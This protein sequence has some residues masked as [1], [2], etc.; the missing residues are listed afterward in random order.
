MKPQ[1]TPGSDS[2][3]TSRDKALVDIQKLKGKAKA[4]QDVL[5]GMVNLEQVISKPEVSIAFGGHC[6]A[7]KSSTL[8]ALLGQLILPVGNKPL[9]GV[10]IEIRSGSRD[11][12]ALINKDGSIR[13]IPCTQEGIAQACQL[14][15]MG[16]RRADISQIKNLQIQLRNSSIPT[17][18]V[19][20]D[21]PGIDDAAEMTD[22]AWNAAIDADL[23]VW[24]LTSR[25]PLSERETD[26]LTRYVLLRGTDSLLLVLNCFLDD[27]TDSAWEE[28]DQEVIPHAQYK[29]NEWLKKIGAKPIQIIPISAVGSDASIGHNRIEAARES[30]RKLENASN[31][32]VIQSRLRRSKQTATI[33]STSLTDQINTLQHDFDQKQ[34]FYDN[35]LQKYK[36][37]KK[38]A[39]RLKNDYEE[40][41]R[42]RLTEAASAIMAYANQ[43]AAQITNDNLKRDQTYSAGLQAGMAQIGANSK[44]NLLNDLRALGARHGITT[45]APTIQQV[46]NKLT[47]T[48]SASITVPKTESSAKWIGMFIGFLVGMFGSFGVAAIPGAILGFVV[49]YFIGNGT[50]SD[51]QA[52]QQLIQQWGRESSSGFIASQDYIN[53]LFVPP[54]VGQNTQYPPNDHVLKQTIGL[55]ADLNAFAQSLP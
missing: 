36:Q 2:A 21:T 13:S 7:G 54:A 23:L 32:R 17:S 16:E 8:N 48:S 24:V 47:F 33:L 37:D 43:Y 50:S 5:F 49:G 28:F 52:A 6:N 20:I 22:R 44:T 25:H 9:T 27:Q 39:E 26:L 38:Q 29:V 18:C 10:P 1:Q 4:Q 40:K 53:T 19:W 34:T 14:L 12:A 15:L 55:Q 51:R 46:Q 30:T 41:V 3:L 42:E 31:T 35:T 45:I 11:E